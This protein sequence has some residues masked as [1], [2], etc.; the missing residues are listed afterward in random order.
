M[1]RI[2]GRHLYLLAQ[3]PF[4]VYAEFFA[5]VRDGFSAFTKKLMARGSAFEEAY[6]AWLGGAER[7][8]WDAMEEGWRKTRALMEAGVERIH[9]MPLLDEKE[10][11][12]GVPDVLIRKDTHKSAFGKWHYVVHEV[13]SGKEVE[14]KHILQAGFYHTMLSALQR[15]EPKHFFIITKDEEG[16]PVEHKIIAS[17]YEDA[18]EDALA[19]VRAIRDGTMVPP[20]NVKNCDE[21]FLSFCRVKA[22]EA[23]DI[24]LVANVGADKQAYLRDAGIH[25]VAQLATRTQDV[26]GIVPTKLEQLRQCAIAYREKRFILLQQ[27]RLPSGDVELFIDFEGAEVDDV[28]FDYL[29]GV[30]VRE[31]KKS[32]FHPFVTATI[33]ERTKMAK[34]LMAFLA[35]YPDAPIFHY[36]PYEKTAFKT[37][38]T[39][40]VDIK[41]VTDRMTDILQVCR[42]CVAPPTSTFSL[43]DIAAALGFTWRDG[44]NAGQS[45]VEFELWQKGDKKALQRILDYNEDDLKALLLLKDWLANPPDGK[46]K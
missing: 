17:H 8:D 2:S 31:K 13:K 12:Q 32:K 15:Y 1:K 40:G 34:E 33:D 25:T 28:K 37:L 29:C 20:P 10:G 27:P 38:A 19:Q 16:K 41:P 11:L 23:D 35:H 36:A 24:S 42:R 45:I 43:K 22:I 5:D 30:I 39:L 6:V 21:P 3:D 18:I 4:L 7:Q 9:G 26:P 44:M 46:R 14:T